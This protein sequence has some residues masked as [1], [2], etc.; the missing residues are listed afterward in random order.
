[1][2]AILREHDGRGKP[3]SLTGRV[4]SHLSLTNPE[5]LIPLVYQGPLKR[6][7]IAKLAKIVLEEASQGDPVSQ[8][9][10]IGAAKRLVEMIGTV[11]NRLGVTNRPTTI[12]AT[13]GLLRPGNPLWQ[14]I[15]QQLSHSY[16]PSHLTPPLLS[17]VLGAILLGSDLIAAT[18]PYHDFMDNL[19]RH[20]RSI[21]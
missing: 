21:L 16:P 8:H 17:P 10:I 15:D 19:T 1:M 3:T 5:A 20:S 14:A 2:T 9:I 18:S 12:A 11:L 7:D 4:L 13:G 6:P